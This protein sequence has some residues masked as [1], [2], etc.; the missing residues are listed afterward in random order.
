[1]KNLLL[2]TALAFTFAVPA[3]AAG[4]HAD[5][6]EEVKA[7]EADGHGD[8]HGDGHAEMMKVGM[9]GDAAKVD[10]TVDVIMVETDDGEMLFKGDDL[11]FSKGETIRFMVRNK[12]ELE[13]E[14]VLDTMA[15]NEKHKMEMADMAGMDMEHDDPNRITLQPRPTSNT[16]P[17][18]SKRSTQP[19]ARLQSR[20]A[21]LSILTCL[22]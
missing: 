20:M 4:T 9:P 5:K 2:T 21:S 16:P 12:G 19:L 14:F 18:R 13:H 8:G 7:E 17:V 15:N 22:R 11:N 1:M 6:H 3:Y 10:R